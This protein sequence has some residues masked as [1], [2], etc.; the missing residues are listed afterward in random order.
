[1]M[2]GQARAAVRTRMPQLAEAAT[3]RARLALVPARTPN[4]RRTPFAVLVFLLLAGGVVGLLMFNTHMQQ[5]AF[6]ATA[7]QRTAD[8]LVAQKQGLDM[9]LQQLRDPQHVA[10]AARRL[11][12]VLPANPAFLKLS[13]GRV[14]GDPEPANPGD[15]LFVQNFK[16]VKPPALNPRPIIVRVPAVSTAAAGNAPVGQTQGSNP[17]SNSGASGRASTN[18]VPAPGRNETATPPATDTRD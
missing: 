6:K 12:M 14:I 9:E 1:M 16:A 7:L 13:T 10:L 2:G 18:T 4:A 11:G 15:A 8:D 5:N 17:G 3:A